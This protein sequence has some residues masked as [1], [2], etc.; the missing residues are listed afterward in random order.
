MVEPG[1]VKDIDMSNYLY[2]LVTLL[3]LVSCKQDTSSKQNFDWLL[4]N[5][6]RTNDKPG[7][8][9]YENWHKMNDSIYNGLG[10]TMV[11]NDTVFKEILLLHKVQSTWT[12]TVSGVN[13][14]PTLF[15]LRDF[16]K[17]YFEAVNPQNEFPKSIYYYYEDNQLK[18]RIT[19]DSVEMLF[20]FKRL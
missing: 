6:Q 19:A 5:Y 1:K 15:R 2:I 3:L 11:Q 8:T 10:Y 13:E 17:N 4:G 12:L 18:A 20:S 14:E 16:K 7:R 9:T